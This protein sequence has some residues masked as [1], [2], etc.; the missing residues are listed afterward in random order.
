MSVI[1]NTVLNIKIYISCYPD[2]FDWIC[3]GLYLYSIFVISIIYVK[4]NKKIAPNVANNRC[5]L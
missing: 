5:K 1:T 2:N 3:D 4:M